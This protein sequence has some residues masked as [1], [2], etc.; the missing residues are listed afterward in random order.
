MS[1]RNGEMHMISA[2]GAVILAAALS[3]PTIWFA[4][5]KEASADPLLEDMEAI[6]ASLAVK[7]TPA[8]Q[9]QKK[10]EE[11]APEEKPEGVSRDEKKVVEENVCKVD[12]DCKSG[13]LCKK[14][15]CEKEKIAKTDDPNKDPLKDFRRPDPDAVTGD[16][17]TTEVGAFNDSEEG[18]AEE[19]KGHPFFQKVAKDFVDNF[20][21]PSILE[22]ENSVGCIHMLA[23]GTI[24]RYKVDPKSGIDTLDDAV[25]RA[26][27]TMKETRAQNPQPPP[28]ELLKQA[29]T[30]WICFNTGKLQRTE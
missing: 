12:T 22:G 18:W 29:T 13:E 14:G 19:S 10:I 9:P 30:R 7:K 11:K 25:E 6:E 5:A 2:L 21:Y 23:D 8:K 15:K 28:V 20:K 1:L 24:K 26:L 3:V 17:P 27:K 16:K 4:E